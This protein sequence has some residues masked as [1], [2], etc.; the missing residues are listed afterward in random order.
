MG[1]SPGGSGEAEIGR[2][3]QQIIGLADADCVRPEDEGELLAALDAALHELLADDRAASRA[4]IARFIEAVQR[5]IKA[6]V[7]AAAMGEP[8]LA[9]ARALLAA[10]AG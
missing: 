9:T 8:Q 3:R 4:G 2:L 5:L 7:L 1:E 6:G 10:L